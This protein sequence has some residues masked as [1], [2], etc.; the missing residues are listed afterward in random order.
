M[1]PR[2]GLDTVKLSNIRKSPENKNTNISLNAINLDRR[3][4]FLLLIYRMRTILTHGFYF[5]I[6]FF[7]AV[8]ID[9]TIYVLNE[10][11]L[12]FLG[13]KSAVYNCEHI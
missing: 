1:G 13:L 9:E 2:A 7:T 5:F 12:Q 10:E 3:R 6:P 8:Y 11:I 4:L